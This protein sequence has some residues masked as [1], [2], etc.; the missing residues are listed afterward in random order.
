MQGATTWRKFRAILEGLLFQNY[1]LAS[2]SNQSSTLGQRFG[3]TLP[4]RLF[5]YLDLWNVQVAAH[6]SCDGDHLCLVNIWVNEHT[7]TRLL[8]DLVSGV[9][10]RPFCSKFAHTNSLSGNSTKGHKSKY[11]PADCSLSSTTRLTDDDFPFP[12]LMQPTGT[13]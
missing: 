8:E 13:P 5:S 1:H 11:S 3:L 6:A 7:V 4:D 2:P 10:V 9:S 12:W